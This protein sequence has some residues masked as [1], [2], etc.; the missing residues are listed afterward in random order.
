[1]IEAATPIKP[2][3]GAV[4]G[5]NSEIPCSN[6]VESIGVLYGRRMN[7]KTNGE[8]EKPSL[9]KGERAEVALRSMEEV[10]STGHGRACFVMF[11]RSN[12]IDCL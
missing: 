7:E 9:A 5:H 11:C 3:K 1:M 12:Q 6:T 8:M 2:K 4:M 10:K